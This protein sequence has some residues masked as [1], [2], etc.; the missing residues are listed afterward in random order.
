LRQIFNAQ[1]VDEASLLLLVKADQRLIC[2]LLT[3]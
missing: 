2:K 3:I 1:E